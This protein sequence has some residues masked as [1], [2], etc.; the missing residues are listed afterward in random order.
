MKKLF[1]LF[2]TG[3]V[4]SYSLKAQCPPDSVGQLANSRSNSLYQTPSTNAT[5]DIRLYDGQG[6]L[7]RKTSA[8]DGMVQFNVSNLPDGNYYLHI[9]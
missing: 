4:I 8:E 3:I 1:F 6:N 9:L 7:L 5:Y 2:L